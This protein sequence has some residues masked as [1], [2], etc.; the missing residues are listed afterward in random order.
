MASLIGANELKRKQMILLDGQPYVILD[1]T[2][3]SPS[4]RGASM[5]VKV[6]V[7]NLLN[8]AVLDKNFRTSEKFEEADVEKVPASFLYSDPDAY[9]FMDEATYEQFALPLA[10]I[11]DVKGYIKE[12]QPLQVLKYN[13]QPVTLEFPVYVELKVTYTEPGIKGDSSAGSLKLA[14]LETGIEVKVPLYV[15]EGDV[16]RVNTQTGEVSGR[17]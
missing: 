8:A 12:G 14:N 5:M 16:V 1:V 6:R 9:Y 7:R 3:S 13:G 17:A 15:K 10:K 2:F 11:A 4:A